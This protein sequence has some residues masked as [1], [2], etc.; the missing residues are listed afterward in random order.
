MKDAKLMRS[1]KTGQFVL[2][3]K[4]GEKFSAVEGLKTTPRVAAT[5]KAMAATSLSSADRRAQV[6]DALRKK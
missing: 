2:T 5:V 4:R 6:K 1:A 3:T